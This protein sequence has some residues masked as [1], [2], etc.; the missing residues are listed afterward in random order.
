MKKKPTLRDVAK[1]AGVSPASVSMILNGRNISR[2]SA[3]TIELVYQTC[4]ELDYVPKQ[5]L[6]AVS[7]GII[8]LICPSMMNPYYATLI[9]SMDQE[10]R[11]RG[12]L[13]LTFPTYWDKKAEEQI[14]KLAATPRIA[15]IVFAMIPQQPDLAVKI[16]RNIPMVTV[17][18]R[19]NT[20][21]ID[22]VE[23]N[24]YE[25]G[26]MLAKHL[27]TLGHKHVAYVST[28]LNSE[29]TARLRRCHGLQDEYAQSCPEGSVTIYSQDV[30]SLRELN[31]TDIEHQV[32]YELTMQCL[33]EAP[34]ITAIA[35][36]ND[37]VA[38]GVL[39]ALADSGKRIP[40][41][42]SVCG[43]DNIYPSR[44]HCVDL[45][46]IEYAIEKRGRLS[47]RL[48]LE[49]LKGESE[50]MDDNSIIKVEYQSQLISRS[51]TGP[52]KAGQEDCKEKGPGI[53][54]PDPEN[55]G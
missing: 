35:A 42:L 15:G 41:D 28:S 7:K 43:F 48:L 36:I 45:T 11:T 49:K 3:E 32:G 50:L 12:Y 13:T 19:S 27:I 6:R 20:L 14:L 22:T 31:V 40:E 18:D 9:Q 17:G 52:A 55:I 4:R 2:F 29:H 1:Q 25:A 37:M 53:I 54:L 5:Q 47:I 23:I 10:A 26:R 21:N 8:L 44:F 39:D 51:S 34:R 30:S 46:S 16:A 38:Y 24:N 33:E